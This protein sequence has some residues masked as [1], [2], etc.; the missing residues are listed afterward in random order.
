MIEVIVSE[1]GMTADIVV[2]PEPEEKLTEALIQ[3]TL[4][5]EGVQAGI[6]TDAIQQLL[7]EKIFDKQVRVA[8]G[9]APVDGKDGYYEYFF[10]VNAGD[11]LPRINDD[12]TVDYSKVIA[13][14][15]AGELLAEYH[16][17]TSGTFG[18]NV[19]ARA[20]SPVKGK[21]LREL[22]CK[23][24]RKDENLYFAELDGHVTLNDN[25]I[26]VNNILEINGDTDYTV[27]DIK[28]NGDIHVLGNISGGVTVRAEGSV[29]VDGVIED[30]KVYADQDII[31]SRG[32][33][34]QG[35]RKD[36]VLMEEGNT[37]VD[38]KGNLRIKFID[39]AFARTDGDVFMDY[40]VGSVIEAEGKVTAKGRKGVI[41]GGST[42]A[43]LGIEANQ[44]G[45]EVGL[46]TKISVGFS[47]NKNAKLLSYRQKA[48]NM[49][50]EL[51]E[52]PNSPK[53]KELSD[54]IQ[55]A[56]ERQQ[57]LEDELWQKQVSPVIVYR[58]IHQNVR[59]MFGETPAPDMSGKD[60]IELRKIN[61]NILCKTIGSYAK[62]LLQ[63]KPLVSREEK[64]KVDK[65]KV[66]VIDDD[67]RFL[68]TIHQFLEEQYQVAVATSGRVARKYLETNDVEIILL[69]YMMSDE[70][71]VEVLKSFRAW[72]KVKDVP[73]VFLTG[74]D[75]KQKILECLSLH[76]AGYIMKPVEK[77]KLF[78]KIRAIVGEREI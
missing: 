37:M 18:Y 17:E 2:N 53:A 55:I 35:T 65:I 16:P 74:L 36:G 9:K 6:D 47:K 15:R 23:N 30:A 42:S 50:D 33:H 22:R 69:D 25:A 4:N 72:D 27:G 68:R 31:V 26:F 67:A 46:P 59:L 78:A 76:P 39:H 48:K 34:G 19:F 77:E 40:A 20:L 58:M 73:V 13:N 63:R 5:L 41:V 57:E 11:G 12:G 52:N 7:Q 54:K 10:D 62:V 44:L 8:T 75:D 56:R 32:I 45:N 66:L 43:L 28:F 71:G 38:A 49:E 29:L 1:D 51:A 21:T 24:V 64:P 3:T 14:V 61:G 60:K 70:N